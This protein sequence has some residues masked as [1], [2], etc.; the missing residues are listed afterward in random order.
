MRFHKKIIGFIK[1]KVICPYCKEHH[2][3]EFEKQRGM[4]SYCDWGNIAEKKFREVEKQK[5]GSETWE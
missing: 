4:C 2:L 1:R 3:K 5:E